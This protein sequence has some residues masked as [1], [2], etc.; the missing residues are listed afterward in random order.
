MEL[1]LH[2]KLYSKAGVQAALAAFSHLGEGRLEKD[3]THYRILFETVDPSTR[4]V[5]LDEFGNFALYQTIV[6]KK[7]WQ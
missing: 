6:G 7:T 3:E 2:K 4:D 5:L 1:K